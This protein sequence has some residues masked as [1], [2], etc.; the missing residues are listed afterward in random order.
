MAEPKNTGDL[1]SKELEEQVVA[2]GNHGMPVEMVRSELAA[3]G[4]KELIK[5]ANVLRAK[6]QAFDQSLIEIFAKQPNTQRQV[7]RY[8]EGLKEELGW[9]ETLGLLSPSD[10]AGEARALISPKETENARDLPAPAGSDYN[11][12]QLGLFQAFLAN[13]DRHKEKLSNAVDLWDSVPRY[14]MS[15][16]EM[17]KLRIQDE[18]LRPHEVRFQHRGSTYTCVITP[19][20]TTDLDGKGRYFYPSASEELVEDALR[21]LAVEQGSG[22]YDQGNRRSGVTFSLYELRQEMQKQGHTRSYQEIVQSLNILSHCVVDLIP[23]GEGEKQ[24][25]SA[26]LPLLAAVSAKQ[27]ETDPDARWAVQFHPLVTAS[28]DEATHRQYDYHLMMS[29]T[30][31]LARWLHKQLVIKYTFADAAKPFQMRYST[32]KRDSSLLEGYSRE[33]KAIEKLDAA[34]A[35][36]RKE[37]VV[38]SYTRKDETGLRKKLLDVVFTVRASGDFIRETRAANR[39]LLEARSSSI[40]P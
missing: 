33:R 18:F 23:D 35:E 7:T 29:L 3:L 4:P 14:A 24:I 20:Y 38:E 13:T 16:Q 8:V 36:L 40:R 11:N 26:C 32:I 30:T 39:R 21:K 31:Q 1:E 12:R 10:I 19:A 25:T 17:G 37:G 2:P 9:I 5:R 27:L 34:F 28:I 22:Y 15:R 6:I